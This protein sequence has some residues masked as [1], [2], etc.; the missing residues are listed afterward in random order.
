MGANN[1]TV[2]TLLKNGNDFSIPLCQY[3]YGIANDK[4]L[5]INFAKTRRLYLFKSNAGAWKNWM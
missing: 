4:P 5:T 1:N 3:S 2:K